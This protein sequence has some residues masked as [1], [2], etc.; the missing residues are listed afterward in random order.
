MAARREAKLADGKNYHNYYFK[1]GY[2][3]DHLT[4][5]ANSQEE[6]V[7]SIGNA[8]LL[9]STVNRSL[10]TIAFEN[11]EKRKALARSDIATTRA[12]TLESSEEQ[13]ANKV[14]MRM[15]STIEELNNQ[16]ANNRTNEIINC[17]R[18]FI[19]LS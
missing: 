2:D 14:I 11:E 3:V 16:T 10:K 12:L 5:S 18:R 8:A 1:Q 17:L 15:F 19:E 7:Q 9:G 13:G 6:Y 4:P